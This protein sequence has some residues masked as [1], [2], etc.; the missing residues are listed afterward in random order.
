MKSQNWA[1]N[2]VVNRDV[3]GA[4]WGASNADSEHPALQDYL[5]SAELA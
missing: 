1:V 5:H 4:G 3:R 2:D